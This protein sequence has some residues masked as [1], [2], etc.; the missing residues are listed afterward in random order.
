MRSP[1]PFLASE[2][3][4][5]HENDTHLSADLFWLNLLYAIGPLSSYIIFQP[6][7]EQT[8]QLISHRLPYHWQITC[9]KPTAQQLLFF[10]ESS[11]ILQGPTMLTLC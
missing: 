1:S 7:T 4:L 5:T 6:P 11:L 3:R 8:H 9:S 10:S 2:E